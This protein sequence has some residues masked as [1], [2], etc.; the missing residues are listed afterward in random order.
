MDPQNEPFP[1]PVVRQVG[2]YQVQEIQAL[3]YPF[4][5][6][7][8]DGMAENNPIVSNLSAVTLNWASPITVDPAKNAR[9]RGDR[10]VAVLARVLG[11]AGLQHPA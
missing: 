7:R 2:D 8:S 9:P 10:P 5:D 4:V 11:T 3:D 6:V 1:M